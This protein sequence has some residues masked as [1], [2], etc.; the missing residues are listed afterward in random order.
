MSFTL[1]LNGRFSGTPKPTGTQVVAYH[2]FDAILR[3]PRGEEAVVFADPRFPG[4]AAWAE[5]P[6]TR[7]VPVPFQD[8]SRG[9]A[10]LWEQFAFPLAA[11]RR[12]ARVAHHPITTCPAWHNGLRTVVTLHDLNFYLHPEWFS[13][14]FSLVLRLCAV[15]GLQRADR[16]VAISDYVAGQAREHFHLRPE[17]LTRVYNGNRPLPGDAPSLPGTPPYILCVGSLQPHKNLPR[18]IEAYRRLRPD[19]PGLELHVVGRPQARFA[20][21]PELAA[22]LETP[23]LKVLGYL[24]EAELQRAYRDARVFCYP[25]L[26]EGF[27]LP[28]L[29][30]ALAG[31][32]VV[33]SNASCLPEIAGPAAELV[34]PLDPGAIAAGLAKMLR[35][36]EEERAR[37][38]ETGAAWAGRFT[39]EA[40]A[41]AYWKIFRAAAY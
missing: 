5:L 8:W 22:L 24:S 3:A 40:A 33:S 16:V 30:A 10:Q 26:E 13:R 27:G 29:E 7:L 9:R 20:A 14:R 18:L 17:R 34:D 39:W 12:G 41:E 1:A 23:G 25:S 11:R 38:L 28:L 35:L 2:L 4:V 21:Q 15:P 36:P 19:F 37:R 32:L 31:T 6:R